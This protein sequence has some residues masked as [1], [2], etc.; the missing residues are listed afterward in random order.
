MDR[1]ATKGI[2]DLF[3]VISE[4]KRNDSFDYM[5]L[6]TKIDARNSMM[7]KATNDRI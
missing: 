1:R 3:E 5:L 2:S 4:I 7:L 6:K